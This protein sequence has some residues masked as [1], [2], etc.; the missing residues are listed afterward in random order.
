MN[1]IPQSEKTAFNNAISQ[2]EKEQFLNCMSYTKPELCEELIRTYDKIDI[3]QSLIK[4]QDNVSIDKEELMVNLNAKV[5]LDLMRDAGFRGYNPYDPNTV[6]KF[7]QFLKTKCGKPN[8]KA[9]RSSVRRTAKK[10]RK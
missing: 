10:K 1:D 3:L 4:L 8:S 5:L 9:G 2:S 6:F 7:G